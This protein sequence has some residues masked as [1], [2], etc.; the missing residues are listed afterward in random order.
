MCFLFPFS[1]SISNFHF[2]F[3]FLFHF[4]FLHFHMP[5]QHSRCIMKGFRLSIAQQHGHRCDL[6]CTYYYPS[7]WQSI[8]LAQARPK[9]PCS[10]TSVS[11]VCLPQQY[12]GHYL[13]IAS[14][15]TLHKSIP[16]QRSFFC[17]DVIAITSWEPD[18]LTDLVRPYIQYL[19]SYNFTTNPP[20]AYFSVQAS[21]LSAFV[22]YKWP[23]ATQKTAKR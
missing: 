2:H 12:I 13:Q 9:M 18:V 4:H 7:M 11:Y 16:V 6:M 17:G 23:K 5:Q 21:S 10:Y 3:Q 1:I 8:V 20:K 15:G 19:K 22:S 14:D